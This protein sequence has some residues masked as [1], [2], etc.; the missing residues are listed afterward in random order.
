MT[1]CTGQNLAFTVFCLVNLCSFKAL[2]CHIHLAT[3]SAKRKTHVGPGPG[4]EPALNKGLWTAGPR[5]YTGL[6][7]RVGRMVMM[8]LRNSGTVPPNLP[9]DMAS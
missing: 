6:N 7:S 8:I 4:I 5:I 2:D 3:S 9:I 1:L